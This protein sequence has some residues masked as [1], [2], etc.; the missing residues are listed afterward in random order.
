MY[1]KCVV[2]ISLCMI[3]FVLIFSKNMNQ[4]KFS[5]LNE[6]SSVM[7][8]EI[9]SNKDRVERFEFGCLMCNGIQVPVDYIEKTF[10][11]PLNMESEQWET[12]EFTSGNP[13]LQ[14]LFPTDF[15]EYDKKE[16]IAEG[17]DVGFL[18]YN[19]TELSACP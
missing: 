8:E 17:A 2:G 14:I 18:V 4:S 16:L 10:Y 13:E 1:K 9:W 15:T 19:Y 6:V 12:L 5:M 11:V 7:S 3:V